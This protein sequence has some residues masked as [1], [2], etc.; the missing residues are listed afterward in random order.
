MVCKCE[1][2]RAGQVLDCDVHWRERLPNAR[3]S[4]TQTIIPVKEGIVRATLEVLLVNGNE[5]IW[6]HIQ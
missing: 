6:E 3:A 4:N 2:L 1:M 5:P